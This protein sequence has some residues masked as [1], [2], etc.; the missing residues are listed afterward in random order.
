MVRRMGLFDRI[1]RLV[2]SNV[3]S[4][5]DKAEDPKKSLELLVSDLRDALLEAKREVVASLATEKQLEKRL[6]EVE[7]EVETWTR[8]AELALR[9]ND[10]ALAREALVQKKK[11][12]ADR[13]RAE[14]E[15]SAAKAH[16]AET[17]EEIQ[18]MEAKVRE[19]EGKQGILAARIAQAKA[20]GGA[21]GLGATGAGP[22]PVAQFDQF[23]AGVDRAEAEADAMREVA[24]ET[25]RREAPE[26]VEAKFRKLEKGASEAT[27][28][29]ELAA[30]KQRVRI[31]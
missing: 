22:T 6:A 28:D 8:R 10:E 26:D 4:L 1:G 16:T 5:L 19:I 30:L 17:K 12:V 3:N 25:G 9:A 2:S 21:A 18:R 23:E 20:G 27:V 15:L 7:K 24:A 11:H 13:D 31:R 14:A 29:D